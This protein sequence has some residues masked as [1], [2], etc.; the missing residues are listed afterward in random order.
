MSIFGIIVNIKK[1]ILFCINFV[2][3]ICESKLVFLELIRYICV[4]PLTGLYVRINV[5]PSPAGVR[6]WYPLTGL[7]VRICDMCICDTVL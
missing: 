1:I 4:S 7:Y 6:C 3:V 2:F 5:D